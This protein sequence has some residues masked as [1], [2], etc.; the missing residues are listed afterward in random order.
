M[1]DHNTCPNC[2]SETAYS[3]WE[4]TNHRVCDK[5]YGGCGYT[6]ENDV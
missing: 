4:G 5:D 1:S 6:E 3:Y 2:G